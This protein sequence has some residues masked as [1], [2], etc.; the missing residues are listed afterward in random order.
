MRVLIV[1]GSGYLGQFLVEAF[2]NEGGH[3]V[4]YTYHS[5][6]LARLADADP[7]KKTCAGY[8]VDVATGEGMEAC[9]AD[10][11]KDAPL[12]LVVNCAAM[13]SPGQCEKDTARATAINVPSALLAALNHVL[14]GNGSADASSGRGERR[15]DVLPRRNVREVC[16]AR[17]RP[18]RAAACGAFVFLTSAALPPGH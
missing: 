12:D 13:S 11:T 15:A 17:C 14:D 6:P 1:G 10:V 5:R 4:G 16:R 3:W 2:L 18:R 9:V 7:E 8:K